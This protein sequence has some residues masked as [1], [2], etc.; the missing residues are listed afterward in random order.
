[1][2]GSFDVGMH[3]DLDGPTP[4]KAYDDTFNSHNIGRNPA[5]G[6]RYVNK[7][8]D[9]A[10][11]AFRKTADPEKQ[12]LELA[13]AQAIVAENLPIIPIYNAPTW[14]QYSTKRFT[15]WANAEKPFV[16]PEVHDAVHTRL[17]QL[18]ALQPVQ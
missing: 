18:L 9:A 8:L 4:Y 11:D 14:Y 7:D 6:H 16:N 12:K 10:L 17:L 2:E 1:M 3:S 15:G 5:T 13:V